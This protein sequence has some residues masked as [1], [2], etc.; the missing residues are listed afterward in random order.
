MKN[1]NKSQRGMHA[2]LLKLRQKM[3]CR[4]LRG[5]AANSDWCTYYDDATAF[6]GEDRAH[7]KHP[8]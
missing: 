6:E 3:L 5:G 7:T 2:M 8:N 1:I 4:W